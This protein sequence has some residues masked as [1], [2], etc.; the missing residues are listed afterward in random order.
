VS[1]E[2]FVAAGGKAPAVA[3]WPEA[4]TLRLTPKLAAIPRAARHPS[5]HPFLVLP[6]RAG[7]PQ[8]KPEEQRS[9]Y[10]HLYPKVMRAA[11][12]RVFG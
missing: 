9:R 4:V 10:W 11:I 6:G 8:P 12:S 2:D 1:L 7:C 5:R 3:V